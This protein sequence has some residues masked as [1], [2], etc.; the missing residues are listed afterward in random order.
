M[1]PA[2]LDS[3]LLSVL[4]VLVSAQHADSAVYSRLLQCS[5]ALRDW[6]LTA[7]PQASLTLRPPDAGQPLEPW[8]VQ[9]EA[10]QRALATRGALPASVVASL[11]QSSQPDALSM[12]P[13]ALRGVRSIAQFSV[14]SDV[15]HGQPD[16]AA[17]TAFLPA[18]ATA[19][20]SLRTLSIDCYCELPDPSLFSHVTS[21]A[22]I[23][24]FNAQHPVLGQTLAAASR[25]LIQLTALQH[26][27][28]RDHHFWRHVDIPWSHLFTLTTTTLTRF[29]TDTTLNDELI[30]A[31]LQHA[32]NLTELR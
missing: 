25:Y 6:V 10:I 12:I 18:L 14:A 32:P 7:A 2:G 13:D 31:L 1:S 9:L 8:R 3:P 20:P 24:T 22:F 17:V 23:T 27:A 26:A 16:R 11:T 21:L 28:P 15:R 5:R 4:H 29:T 19:L 30:K